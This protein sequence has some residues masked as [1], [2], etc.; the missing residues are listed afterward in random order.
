MNPNTNPRGALGPAS[1]GASA[2][3]RWLHANLVL[4]RGLPLSEEQ[5]RQLSHAVGED[6]VRLPMFARRVCF[7]SR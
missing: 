7:R 1:C 4:S 2:C 5:L 6:A 3:V